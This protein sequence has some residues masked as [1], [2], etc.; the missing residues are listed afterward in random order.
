MGSIGEWNWAIATASA[1]YNALMVKDI[2]SKWSHGGPET[3]PPV[4]EIIFCATNLAF[5]T[6][7]YLKAAYVAC[8]GRPPPKVHNLGKIF[9]NISESDRATILSIYESKF[10]LD[11]GNL[12]NGEIWFKLD[13]GDPPE[14]KRPTSLLE[15]LNHYSMCYEDW[16]YIFAINKKGNS[17]NLRCLHY[18]RLMCLCVAVDN[19]LQ[20]RFP[21]TVRKNEI[22]ILKNP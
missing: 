14:D 3:H 20:E 12:R 1:R 10:A 8:R 9:E 11:F 5:A 7:L 22:T 2:F 16:R 21:N 13:D 17:S 4:H 18:S 6:E 19:F 15:V